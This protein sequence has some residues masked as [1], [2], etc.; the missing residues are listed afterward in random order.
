MQSY[1]FVCNER[2][3]YAAYAKCCMQWKSVVRNEGPYAIER[4]AF[5]ARVL[6]SMRKGYVH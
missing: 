3:L 2:G 1:G 4:V 6:H 5:I